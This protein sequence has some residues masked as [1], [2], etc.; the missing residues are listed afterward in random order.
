MNQFNPGPQMMTP[1]YM[2]AMEMDDDGDYEDNFDV[3]G[4][5]P[6]APELGEMVYQ[7]ASQQALQTQMMNPNGFNFGG[8]D[9]PQF[10]NR[11][12][13][14]SSDE[15]GEGNMDG[16][17]TS[18]LFDSKENLRREIFQIPE[19]NIDKQ[20]AYL[21]DQL[22]NAIDFLQDDGQF[23]FDKTQANPPQMNF[24]NM[25]QVNVTRQP[26]PEQMPNMGQLNEPQQPLPSEQPIWQ[27]YKDSGNQ[28]DM[29]QMNGQPQG[30]QNMDQI[31]T[32]FAQNQ[33]T[34][35][36]HPEQMAA[37]P[38]RNSNAN[39]FIWRFNAEDT[40]DDSLPAGSWKTWG[41]R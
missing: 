39:G 8:Q 22:E 28:F 15:D 6:Y 31:N 18:D 36:E 20:A 24:P 29:N 41:K 10:E 17:N 34:M 5:K 9:M 38:Q 3:S 23:G 12:L 19:Q 13:N 33:Q 32:Q 37:Q 2:V 40:D 21:D 30:M 35:N 26:V 16:F 11:M 14:L 4:Y 7:G 1:Q 27:T 25:N